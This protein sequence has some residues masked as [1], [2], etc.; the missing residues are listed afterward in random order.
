[1]H[2]VG[3]QLPHASLVYW[4]SSRPVHPGAALCGLLTAAAMRLQGRYWPR[5]ASGR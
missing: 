3:L 4:L 2:M 1:M 5:A